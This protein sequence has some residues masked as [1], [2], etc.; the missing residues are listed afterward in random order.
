M[1]LLN[2]AHPLTDDHLRQIETLTGQAIVRVIEITSQIDPQQPLQPQVVAMADATGLSSLEWQTHPLLTAP[3][4][5]NF[6][7]VVLVAELHGRC[8]YFPAMLRMRSVPGSLPPRYEVAEI[9]N[10]QAI[11]E[12][13]RVVVSAFFEGG[14]F[15]PPSTCNPVALSP[16][17]IP[18][19]SSHVYLTKHP[20]HVK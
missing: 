2:F 7:A 17:H 5:L 16:L 8:G 15:L 11:R 13:A 20:R 1:I 4:S 19:A 3:P 10:L 18:R 12:E 9:L 14:S 6:I